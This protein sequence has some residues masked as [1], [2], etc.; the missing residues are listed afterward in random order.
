MPSGRML[1][2]VL[3][4]LLVSPTAAGAPSVA[5]MPSKHVWIGCAGHPHHVRH[6][7]VS[8]LSCSKATS[9]VRRGKFDLTPGGPV[10]STP[11][12]R[13]RSP[14][15]PPPNGPRFTVC[16]WHGRAFRFYSFAEP[17]TR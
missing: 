2:V 13:C 17:R 9:A 15:G 16:R 5:A 3:A 11:R 4:G 14:V 6:V 8:R 7:Q 10:F 1:L 12:F